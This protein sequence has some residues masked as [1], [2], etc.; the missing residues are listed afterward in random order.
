[1]RGLLVA[2]VLLI[3][4]PALAQSLLGPSE[5]RDAVVAMIQAQAPNAQIEMRDALGITVRNPGNKEMPEFQV[6]FDN[7]YREYQGNPGALAEFTARWA[8]FATEMPEHSQMAERVVSVV[9]SRL[10]V[11]G[12]AAEAERLA[13][14]GGAG[15]RILWRPL[16]GDLVEVL[17]FDGAETIQYA[18]P[19]ALEELGLT[20]EQA[21]ASTPNN[22][23]ARLGELELGG[24][25]GADR[26]V[27][28][29]G[30][31]G[32]TPS[33]LLPG[34]VCA[35]AEMHTQLFLVVDRNGYIAADRADPIAH[36]QFR[37]LLDELRAS[38]DAFS[39][40]PL[41][42]HN[43]TVAEVLLTD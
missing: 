15:L 10:T 16:A 20:V 7:A 14:E 2:L 39:V 13:A 8:R 11:E 32:L 18:T 41:G 28:V 6:N 9:R 29:T 24:V 21:W 19:E 1:M 4:P 43:G 42:C 33:T 36:T 31:N 23:P 25:E 12:M 40:T 37:Q 17:V 5:F 3:A 34:G 27:Y 38:S 22:L 26:L 35:A 30:G